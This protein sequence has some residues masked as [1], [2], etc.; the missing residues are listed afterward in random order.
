MN[1]VFFRGKTFKDYM[2]MTL[3]QLKIFF[4]KEKLSLK[5]KSIGGESFQ[6]L[7]SY[8]KYLEALGL[9]YLD[10]NRPV[11]SLSGGEFQRLNLSGQL[12]LC[13]SQVLYVLDEPTVGLHPRDTAR[14]IALLREL[15]NL[16]NTIVV[17]EHDQDV[18]KNSDYVI[19]M[20]PLAGQK[21]GEVLWS[22]SLRD[23]LKSANSNT[24]P[25]LKRK[26]LLLKTARPVNKNSYR[27]QL[28]L[29]KC[30]GRNLKNVDL[31]VPL[32]RFVVVT[33]VSGSGKSSLVT[34]TLYPALTKKLEGLSLPCLPFG[35]LS[36]ADFLNKTVLM[37]QMDMTRSSRSSV[38][39]YLKAFDLIRQSFA[40][41]SLAR[42]K[43]L[44][45][46][47]FS[48]NVEGGRC[49]VC[50][51][52]GYQE[53]DMVFMDSLKVQCEECRGKK[54]K[55]GILEVRLKKKNIIE[56]LNLTVAEGAEF[57]RDSAALLRIFSALKEVGLDYVTLG[58]SIGSLSGGERQRLKLSR[59]LLKSLHEKTLYIL[60]EPT[61]G[62]HFKELEIL[63]KLMERLVDT[64]GSF[65][66]V[67]HNLEL[68]KEADYV[69][70]IGPEAGRRGGQ[71]VFEGSPRQLIS[72]KKSHTGLF[73]RQ[74]AHP[75]FKK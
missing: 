37:N 50:K 52:L 49:P 18:M 5:E 75:V 66:V 58:Q 34:D 2:K 71:I 43:G 64:G 8:L 61:K 39:S 9:S 19:E 11:S 70:D 30:S 68:I 16:G 51:G 14:M 27:F 10:L 15:K 24:A 67:E 17:V 7:S 45:A 21:G 56:V 40:E 48:L 54:F 60:D 57:F 32:N 62:L 23:F 25:Y 53:L 22:G 31:F 36:G 13:L 6:A 47:H 20:G 3:G 41:T 65:L 55:N 69:I 73:L 12:G 38:V 44:R 26:N 35:E 63:L 29:K 33:G 72:C 42:R 46:S 74:L 1:A 28:T 59:E 4:E